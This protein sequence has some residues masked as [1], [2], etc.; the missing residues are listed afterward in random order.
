M[1]YPEIMDCPQFFLWLI[2]TELN[3]EHL[4]KI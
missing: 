2:D 1:V 3:L 4:Y